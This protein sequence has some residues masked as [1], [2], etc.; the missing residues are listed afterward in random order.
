MNKLL[1]NKK[2]IAA[3]CGVSVRTI[4]LWVSQRLIPVIKTSQRKNL[5]RVDGVMESLRKLERKAV[6]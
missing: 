6:I 5:F 4:D 1:L 3:L 2:E